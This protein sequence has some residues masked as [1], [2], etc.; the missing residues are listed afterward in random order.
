MR[1]LIVFGLVGLLVVV[2]LVNHY[3]LHTNYF[4]QQLLP[5]QKYNHVPANIE[6]ANVGTSHGEYGLN[7]ADCGLVGFNFGLSS[8]HFQ[9]D[10][11]LLKYY[12]RHFQKNAV[13]LIPVSYPSFG[14]YRKE[15][16]N[17]QKLRYYQI[18]K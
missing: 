13:L 6:V 5:L 3:Y 4:Q 9:Y 18:A 2:F 14:A 8:Q 1:C 11:R 15:D 16:I 17:A 7:Y 12:R 10:L